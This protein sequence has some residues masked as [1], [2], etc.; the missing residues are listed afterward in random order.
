MTRILLW[1]EFNLVKFFMLTN[2]FLKLRLYCFFL[3]HL[4]VFLLSLIFHREKLDSWLNFGVG[5]LC[6]PGKM[7]TLD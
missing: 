7:A 6:Q 5:M 2:N 1:T 3:T 4:T